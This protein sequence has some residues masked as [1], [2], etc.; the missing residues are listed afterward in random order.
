MASN[1]YFKGSGLKITD[2]AV[3][4]KGTSYAKNDIELVS[5]EHRPISS[6]QRIGAAVVGFVLLMMIAVMPQDAAY[7]G[8]PLAIIGLASIGS[9]IFGVK[10]HT[11]KIK[12]LAGEVT[13]LI[14][15]NQR[16][17]DKAKDALERYL[18][19]PEQPTPSAP[20]NPKQGSPQ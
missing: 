3:Q 12:T 10:T 4:I 1:V 13:A 15:T 9:A 16:Q 2:T 8:A 11:L 5:V 6:G 18:S 19:Q 17:A 7:C 20:I 14:T